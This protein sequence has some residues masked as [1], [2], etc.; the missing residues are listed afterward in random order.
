M[1]TALE[2]NTAIAKRLLKAFPEAG[3]I[4]LTRMLGSYDQWRKSENFYYQIIL[5]EVDIL[6]S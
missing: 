1:V 3:L 6:D 2:A 4:T 5:K